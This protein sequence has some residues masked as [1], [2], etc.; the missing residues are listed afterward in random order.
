MMVNVGAQVGGCDDGGGIVGLIL[1]GAEIELCRLESAGT[2][3]VLD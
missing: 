1:K 3:D 2:V